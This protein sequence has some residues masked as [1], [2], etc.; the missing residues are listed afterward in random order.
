MRSVSADSGTTIKFSKQNE[1]FLIR[2]INRHFS[3]LSSWKDFRVPPEIY[4]SPNDIKNVFMIGLADVTAHI[5]SSNSAFGLPYN[6]RVYIEIPANWYMVVDIGNLLFDLDIPIQNI[7]WGHPNMRDPEMIE[8]RKGKK[9]FWSKEHQIKIFADEFEK[10]GFRIKHKAQALKDLAATNR[11]EWNKSIH[12]KISNAK[13]EERRE[14]LR[15]KLDNIA[16]LHHKYY[17]ETTSRNN[18]KPPHLMEA[19][20]KIPLEIRGKHYDSWK[21]ICVDLGYKKKD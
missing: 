1:D 8:Y 2:E 7:D 17:W 20:D 3:R 9:E 6:H 10:I 18:P 14:K 4:N 12:E 21:E 15:Y 19:S 16:V 5:R 11:D 13:K